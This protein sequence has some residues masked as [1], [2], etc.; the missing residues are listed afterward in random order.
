[1]DLLSRRRGRSPGQEGS[2]QGERAPGGGSSRSGL[3]ETASEQDVAD[4]ADEQQLPSGEVHDGALPSI[5]DYPHV[6][7]G[8]N[9]NPF[10]SADVQQEFLYLQN[11]AEGG[12][13]TREEDRH[14]PYDA[15]ESPAEMEHPSGSEAA[16]ERPGDRVPALHDSVSSGGTLSRLEQG[17]PLRT[18]T[19]D[20]SSSNEELAS[21]RRVVTAMV[22]KTKELYARM[23][24]IEERS[25]AGS[26]SRSAT[27]FMDV[28]LG[29]IRLDGR[30]R[31][32]VR[33]PDGALVVGPEAPERGAGEASQLA[34]LRQQ[35]QMLEQL[36]TQ[37]GRFDLGTQA[38]RFDIPGSGAGGGSSQAGMP[39]FRT[40][41][42]P[43][44]S[45]EGRSG[46]NVPEDPFRVALEPRVY[47][48][49]P[50][51]RS[52]QAVAD[53]REDGGSG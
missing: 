32:L 37:A 42:V 15:A 41:E 10:W 9:P 49:R 43:L 19:Q 33:G 30:T 24:R 8:V 45:S 14:P 1:M 51:S 21:M 52:S 20:T 23:E 27:S 46:M 12:G 39:N 5:M 6:G 13:W 44:N 2:Q 36:S 28:P 3:Q 22:E 35:V 50:E 26:S 53:R 25:H 38:G 48:P 29:T 4:G 40:V 17:Q 31:Q 18:G 11:Y 7:M 47:S 34:Q 16:R